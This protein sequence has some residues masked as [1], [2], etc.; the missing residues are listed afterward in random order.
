[1][2]GGMWLPWQSGREGSQGQDEGH[3]EPGLRLPALSGES[4]QNLGTA[5]QNDDAPLTSEA[6]SVDFY[7]LSLQILC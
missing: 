7:P 5:Q 2:S 1:M 4:L 6:T 3:K